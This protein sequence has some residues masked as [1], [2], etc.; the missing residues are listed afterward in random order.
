MHLP[1]DSTNCV[2][3]IILRRFAIELISAF[4]ETQ[5]F[6]NFM[7]KERINYPIRVFSTKAIS[8]VVITIVISICAIG[9]FLALQGCTKSASNDQ[10][11]KQE[12]T[13]Y[14]RD[15][16]Q[17]FE[18]EF[19]AL[20]ED[21]QQSQKCYCENALERI[22]QELESDSL[23]PEERHELM[24]TKFNIEKELEIMTSILAR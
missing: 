9:G 19:S 18:D 16:W 22:T 8:N 14:E 15:E 10:N 4:L 5:V 13:D 17:Q 24:L 20:P 12:V 6:I 7:K 21:V 2:I 1:L 11:S 23:N 3:S